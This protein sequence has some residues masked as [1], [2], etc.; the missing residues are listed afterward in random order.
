LL[1]LDAV[2]KLLLNSGSQIHGHDGLMIKVA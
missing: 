2:Y 1:G